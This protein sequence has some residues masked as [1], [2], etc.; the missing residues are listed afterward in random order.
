M[1]G[2]KEPNGTLLLEKRKRLASAPGKKT[3]AGPQRTTGVRHL[4][5][6]SQTSAKQLMFFLKT[7]QL[8]ERLT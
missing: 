1:S 2:I 4:I 3:G 8:V 7:N 5:Q 6:G